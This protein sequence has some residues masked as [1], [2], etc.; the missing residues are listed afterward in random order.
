MQKKLIS[1]RAILALFFFLTSCTTVC[2]QWE[3]EEDVSCCE[4]Y[5]SSKMYLRPEIV[6]NGLEVE[7][8]YTEKA[9]W[10]YLNIRCIPLS[11][12]EAEVFYTI[13]DVSY[14]VKAPCLSGGQRIVMPQAAVDN[15]T[16]ALLENKTVQISVG[17]YHSEIT[18][19]EFCRHFKKMQRFIV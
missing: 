9:S 11:T 4:G 17:R 8:I 6:F 18:P 10:M 19:K 15:I 2:R 7:M 14:S 1:K 13:N 16:A 5:T 12:K 3:L